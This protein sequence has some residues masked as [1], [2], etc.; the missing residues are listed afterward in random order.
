[1]LLLFITIFY[2]E[3]LPQD[4]RYDDAD[5]S[6]KSYDVGAGVGDIGGLVWVLLG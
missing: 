1:M 6:A 3:L 5:W 4:S 2:H